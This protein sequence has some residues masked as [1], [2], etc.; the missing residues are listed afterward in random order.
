MN[1]RDNIL[2]RLRRTTPFKDYPATKTNHIIAPIPYDAPD[3]VALFTEKAQVLSAQVHRASNQEQALDQILSIIGTDKRV[4]AW[5]FEH[6]PLE[7]LANTLHANAI[8]I[9]KSTDANIRVG[10]TGADAGLAMTGSLVISTKADKYRHTSLLPAV[11]IAVLH[12]QQILPHLDEWI[13]RQAQDLESFRQIG[14]HIIITGASRTADIAMELVLGAH[15]PAKLH[16]II[17]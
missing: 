17:I 8:T 12:H 4:L 2:N 6:I 1:T 11:H 5:N 10:I 14:N 13:N 16:I 15:G 9:G 3:L 7:N